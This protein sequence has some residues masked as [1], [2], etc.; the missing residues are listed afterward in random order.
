MKDKILPPAC[1]H[2]NAQ[3]R[4]KFEM[5]S[6]VLHANFNH[7]RTLFEEFNALFF[8]IPILMDNLTMKLY[9]I[10]REFIEPAI[11]SVLVLRFYLYSN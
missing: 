8:I 7:T 4:T 1:D 10:H 5:N 2:K 3:L 9:L 11:L 6:T